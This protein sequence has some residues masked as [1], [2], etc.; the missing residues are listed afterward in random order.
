MIITDNKKRLCALLMA[1]LLLFAL[2]F[3]HA[4]TASAESEESAALTEVE[5]A[6]VDEFL[7]AI[8]PNTVITL[9]GRSYDLTRALGYGVFGS[10]YYCWNEIYDDGWELE[11]DKV[12]N[13]TIRAARPGTE[14]VTVPRYAC[15][16]KFVECENVALEGFTAGHTDGP[17]YCTGAVINMTDCNWMTVTNCDLYGCGT[18]GLELIRTREVRAEGT[19]IRDCSYG[20]LYAANSCGIY[21][22]GCSIH[23]IE[24]YGVFSLN[25]SWSTAI[26]NTTI[27]DCKVT[28]LL[29][30]SAAKMF[31]LAGCDVSRNTFDGMFFSTVFQPVVDN[32]SFK[33]NNCANG[34]YMDTWQ[35]SER[36]VKPDGEPYTDAELEAL[37]RDGDSEWTEPAVEEITVTAPAVSEDGMI[38]VHNVDELLASIAPDTAIFLEDGVYDLSKSQGY[39]YASGDYWYW[40]S[41]YDGPG[42][43]IHGVDN[44]SIKANGPHR[45]RIVA[46]P[47]Y[48][49]VMSFESCKGLSLANF[50]AGHTQDVED[51][52]CAGGV[53]SLMDCGDFKVTDCSLYGCGILGITCYNCRGGEVSY[54]EIH[55]CSNGACY[56]HN[57]RDIALTSCNIHDIP[58]YAYQVY[59]CRNITADG[60]VI[61]EGSSW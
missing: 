55:D 9:T 52:G 26:L 20:A 22:D 51:Y 49:E 2:F 39:G 11:I 7:K 21:L 45:A 40:M 35:K 44:L 4:G 57:S 3:A 48:C 50:T 56:F 14:I 37:T 41:C 33:D 24:G 15:V 23:G 30:L 19:T 47:R 34:W 54:T 10:K 42:L 28:C 27:R 13:L 38:H 46:E 36:A 29:D 6:T 17:G 53:L 61:P 8:A 25:A 31:Q 60:Q 1:A 59:D 43:V 32:C 5:A 18:Y 12:Q 16:L 58:N